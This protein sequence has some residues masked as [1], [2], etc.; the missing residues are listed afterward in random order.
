MPKLRWIALVLVALIALAACGSDDP[1]EENDSGSN[2]DG[3]NF[4]EP[5]TDA[6]AYPVF[7]NSEI[8]VGENRFVTGINNDEDA[9]IGSP[10]IEVT[11]DFYDLEKS[12]TRVA[13]TEET[14]FIPI[15]RFRGVY[16]AFATFD[17]SGKWGSVVHINGDGVDES[18]PAGFDVRQESSTPGV[19]EKVPASD[20]PTLD[21]VDK[22]KEISSDNDP[23]T[24]M[25]QT[26]VKDAVGKEPFVLIFATPK[27][28][29]TAACAPMLDHTKKVA[30]D[31]P[32]LTF[33]HVEPY[34]LEKVPELE[35][36]KPA[37]EWGLPSEPWVFV[38]GADGKLIAKFEGV[39]DAEGLRSAIDEL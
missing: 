27:F 5:F 34:D 4:D 10:E 18:V 38:V 13:F 31:Y 16:E 28:C 17:H 15:D 37:L 29:Q 1:A 23:M 25:Y 8:V 11:I 26:S 39:L 24:R 14:R 22:I 32:D 33:I 6:K 3:K 9:P 30:V 21:D 35:P 12:D 36:V 2:G 19:G 20:T 7:V